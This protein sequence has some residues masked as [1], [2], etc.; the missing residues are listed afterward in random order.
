[1]NLKLFENIQ[2]RSCGELLSAEGAIKVLSPTKESSF[3][4]CLSSQGVYDLG[5]DPNLGPVL[6]EVV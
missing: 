2:C 6:K 3:E 1:M 5:Y 4:N